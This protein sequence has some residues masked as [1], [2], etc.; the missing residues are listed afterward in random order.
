M[1]VVRFASERALV[2][3]GTA[4]LR[5]EF[6]DRDIDVRVRYEVQ[7]RGAIPDVVFFRAGKSRLDYVVTVEFKLSNWR[8][9]VVQAFKNRN[10]GNESYVVMDHGSMG[11]AARYLDYFVSAN[12]GLLS[13][14]RDGELF[15]WSL[16]VPAVP[17]SPSF[18]LEFGRVLLGAS[19]KRLTAPFTRSVRGGT[20]WEPLRRQWQ[21]G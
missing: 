10:V 7:G 19:R 11:H 18:A 13:I 8:R 20:A 12:V 6:S 21:A 16:P 15:V 2:R 1:S 5:S 3:S 9:A 4:I 14:S 17:F